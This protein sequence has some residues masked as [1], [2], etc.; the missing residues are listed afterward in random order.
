MRPGALCPSLRPCLPVVAD[1][2]VP[3][4]ELG[5]RINGAAVA[6]EKTVVFCDPA[7]PLAERLPPAAGWLA[8]IATSSSVVSRTCRSSGACLS[9]GSGCRAT[10]VTGRLRESGPKMS[11]EPVVGYLS[12]A[13]YVLTVGL[14]R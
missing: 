13:L 4:D 10:A 2:I 5:V 3:T 12:L 7:D 9:C 6:S 1:T 11:D 14:T 8:L